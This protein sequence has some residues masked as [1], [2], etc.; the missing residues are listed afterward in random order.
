MTRVLR[1]TNVFLLLHVSVIENIPDRFSLF[2]LCDGILRN[3]ACRN[4]IVGIGRMLIV[5]FNNIHIYYAVFR[6][7]YMWKIVIA[8]ILKLSEFK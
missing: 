2:A 1:K 8:R 5:V 4:S 3:F 6:F 7:R